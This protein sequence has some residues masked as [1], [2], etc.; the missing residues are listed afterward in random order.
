[1]KNNICSSCFIEVLRDTSAY[2]HAGIKYYRGDDF[3]KGID[4]SCKNIFWKFIGRCNKIFFNRLGFKII[5]RNMFDLDHWR[6]IYNWEEKIISINSILTILT[7][8]DIVNKVYSLIGNMNSKH[9]FIWLLKQRMSF[10][11][12]GNIS[13]IIYPHTLINSLSN[14]RTSSKRFIT[15]N[16]K[17]YSIL[18]IMDYEI[19]CPRKSIE[20]FYDTWV[21]EQYFLSRIFNPAGSSIVISAGAFVGETSIWLSR[22]LGKK[23]KVFAFEPAKEYF[24]ILKLNIINNNLSN[25]IYANQIGLWHTHATLR[26]IVDQT[27]SR[28]KKNGKVKI[29]AVSLDHF[30][31]TNNIERVDYIKMDIEGAELNALKGAIKTITMFKP[32]LA[33]SVYHKWDDIF[34]IPLFLH[35]IVPEY[36]F[37]FSHKK[38]YMKETIL[39][40]TC[41]N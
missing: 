35:S 20:S 22:N 36:S 15:V 5:S 6:S 27:S 29:H 30:I 32:K 4:I 1:M 26:F 37:F 33:I 12:V 40:A 3:K 21:R 23:G 24:D 8:P 41:K 2:L 7:D 34:T 10:A 14:N 28:C 18:K 19:I 16:R 13:E 17:S 39:F 11:L 25:T 38:N 9:T 31:E